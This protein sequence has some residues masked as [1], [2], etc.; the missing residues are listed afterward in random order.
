MTDR[1]PQATHRLFGSKPPFMVRRVTS[2]ESAVGEHGFTKRY[3]LVYL[4]GKGLAEIDMPG[5]F[6]T[7]DT[8]H[9]TSRDNLL[10]LG[11]RGSGFSDLLAWWRYWAEKHGQPLL[12][13]DLAMPLPRWSVDFD[14]ESPKEK[15][16]KEAAA[17][18]GSA[19]RHLIVTLRSEDEAE[20]NRRLFEFIEA[21]EELETDRLTL[22]FN[23]VGALGRAR[24]ERFGD[25]VGLLEERGI[26]I[27]F[28]FFSQADG[29]LNN[30]L[31]ASGMRRICSVWRMASMQAG[32]II[33]L[34]RGRPRYPGPAW[35]GERV[36]SWIE[37]NSLPPPPEDAQ[38]QDGGQWDGWKDG[39]LA[40][41]EAEVLDVSFDQ[42]RPDA[43]KADSDADH[44]RD[45]AFAEAVR[46]YTGGQPLL[47][48][49]LLVHL[50]R[51]L[52]PTPGSSMPAAS[53][54]HDVAQL[55]YAS[56]PPIHVHWQRELTHILE[57]DS[58]L[59]TTLRGYCAGQ[60][61][62]RRPFPSIE[63]PLYVAGWL[64]T[65]AKGT[66][67]FRSLFHREFARRTIAQYDE[68]P[69]EGRTDD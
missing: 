20:L 43:T 38:W 45:R 16:T 13:V 1:E 68:A 12:E 63:R 18:L 36:Q 10:V 9:V 52:K 69:M 33:R 55:L 8:D 41:L 51:R 5:E 26:G 14:A 4:G 47:V 32:E 44:V 24:T 58:G 66:W 6:R 11:E 2:D 17:E 54:I 30:H 46:A 61:R 42:E 56:P 28:V 65:D 19:L 35:P 62:D 31:L 22:L 3:P 39:S 25:M 50:R 53:R 67:G 29:P 64:D 34:A 7:I 49:A 37:E 21:A 57:E 27:R 40:R 48:Q 60:R 23:H 59:L 15:A